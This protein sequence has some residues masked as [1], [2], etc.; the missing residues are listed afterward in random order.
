M[1]YLVFTGLLL[2]ACTATKST[3]DSSPIYKVG[4]T[5]GADGEFYLGA[6]L[7]RVTA[8]SYGRCFGVSKQLQWVYLAE[9]KTVSGDV[10]DDVQVCESDLK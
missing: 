7:L 9:L 1:K 5:F 8:V 10:I 2:V 3:L 4:D 6:G